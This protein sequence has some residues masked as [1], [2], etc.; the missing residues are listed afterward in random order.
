M[1]K[2]KEQKGFTLIEMLIVVAIIAILVAVS[3]PMVSASLE[4][5]RQVTDAANERAAKT[6]IITCY[7]TDTEYAP[8]KK[9]IADDDTSVTTRKYYVYDAANGKLLDTNGMDGSTILP[10]YG[11]CSKHKDRFLLLWIYKNGEVEMLWTSLIPPT[12]PPYGN[13]NL[14]SNVLN[15]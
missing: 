3:I 7:L 5:A 14:C 8:G 4:R 9:V 6:A 12:R 10:K 1:N 2:V 15:D 13:F 11:K